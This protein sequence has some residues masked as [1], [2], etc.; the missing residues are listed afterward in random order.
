MPEW[1]SMPIQFRV[2]LT[3]LKVSMPM[4]VGRVYPFCRGT[5]VGMIVRVAV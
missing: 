1:V 4:N 3:V 5:G 2:V